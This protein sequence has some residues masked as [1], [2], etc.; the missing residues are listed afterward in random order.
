MGIQIIQVKWVDSES[1]GHPWLDRS[2]LVEWI[3]EPDLICHSAG[4]LLH[5][6]EEHILLALSVTDDQVGLCLKIPQVA[7]LERHDLGDS[8]L[9]IQ[10]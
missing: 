6:N 5:E 3:N 8:K 4:F 2:A 10:I 9:Q 1:N 7:I